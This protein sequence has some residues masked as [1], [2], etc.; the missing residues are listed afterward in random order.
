MRY[1]LPVLL[2]LAC[3]SAGSATGQTFTD[4]SDLL[5]DHRANLL[6]S[7][8]RNKHFSW[9]VSIA[10]LD[11]NGLPDIHEPGVLYLQ[12]GDGS[13]HSS[14][15]WLGITYRPLPPP[16]QG[17]EGR[18]LFGSVMADVDD[19]GFNELVILDILE[20]SSKVFQNAYGIRLTEVSPDNG[21]DFK[22]LGQGAAFADFN[23][24]GPLDLFFGEEQGHNQLFLGDGNGAFIEVTGL[25]G[26]DS[27]V[28]TYGVAAADYDNDGDMDVF[29]AACANDPARSVNL[30]FRNRGDGTFEEVGAA[31]GINDNG[32]AWGVNF[33]DYDRDGWLDI[34]VANMRINFQDGRGNKNK[35]Y[36]NLGN[37]TFEDVSATAGIEGNDDSYGSSVA[38]FDNDGWP[39]IWA[40]NLYSPPTI[41][42][43]NGDGTFRDIYTTTGLTDVFANLSVAVAD[44]NGDGWVDAYTGADDPSGPLSRLLFNDPGANHWLTLRLIQ[45]APNRRAIGARINVWTNGSLQI[46]DIVAGDGFVSQNMDLSAHFGLGSATTADSIIVRWPDGNVDRWEQ[47]PGDTSLTLQKG[48]GFNEPPGLFSTMPAAI[49]VK[50]SRMS[51]VVTVWEESM[52]PEGASVLYTVAVRDSTGEV[53]HV[54]EPLQ[55]TYYIFEVDSTALSGLDQWSF[56]V[57]ATDGLNVRRSMDTGNIVPLSTHTEIADTLPQSLSVDA[58][59]PNPARDRVHLNV[60]STRHGQVSW[61]LIDA[62]GRQVERGQEWISGGSQQL[63][64]EWGRHA[65]GFYL[66][67][68]SDG[69]NRVT[70]PVILTP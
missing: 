68:L 24:D 55:D 54:S 21:I 30:L 62:W 33:L 19:D 59:W 32:N 1:P 61:Q 36:R 6:D 66:L 60:S 13:F 69:V 9:S 57:A 58:L 25:A 37:G 39:D 34:H 42:I 17:F 46:R 2:V 27:S 22:G 26:I 45:E 15:P 40:A 70:R 49:A 51:E 48:G 47:V 50:S 12:Q 35:L 56:V 28:Q 29:I 63:E 8:D 31:A 38:D 14:L 4:R 7:Q 23:G 53:V 43:N 5:I 3:L 18:G 65:A 11:G 52:D 20:D 64:M 10:D 16:L 67:I 41:W 44:I